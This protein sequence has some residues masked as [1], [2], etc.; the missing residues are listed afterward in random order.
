MQSAAMA[1]LRNKVLTMRERFQNKRLADPQT[2][3]DPAPVADSDEDDDGLT[4]L[5]S[6]LNG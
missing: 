2:D 4:P 3:D 5:E 6:E 1:G